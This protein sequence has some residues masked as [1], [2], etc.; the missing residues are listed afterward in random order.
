[1]TGLDE[2]DTLAAEVFD[3]YLVKKDLAPAVPRPA[4]SPD[5]CRRIHARPILRHD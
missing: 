3:G 2:L 4:S 5:I 1:M